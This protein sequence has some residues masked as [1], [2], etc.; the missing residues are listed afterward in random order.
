MG[1]TVKTR[2]GEVRGSTVDGVTVFKGIPYA[3][4]PWGSR[5]M[6][7]PLPV[8]SWSGVRDAT[9]FGAA[10]PALPLAP[11]VA[12]LIPDVGVVPGEDC[13]NLNI[14]TPDM[15]AMGLPVMVWITG[16]FFEFGVGA[17]YD[18]RRFARDGVVCV[19]LNYRA[20]AEGFLDLGDGMADLGLLDQVAALEWVRENIAAFGGD[21]GNVTVFGESAGAMSIAVLLAMPRAE[22]LFRRAIL[23]SGAANAVTPTA[24]AQR[25]ARD[26]AAR[27]GVPA[28]R[29]AIAAV[30]IERMLQAQA[31][32][33]ADL[34]ADP[35]RFGPEVA[36]GRLPWQPSVDGDVVP[37]RPIDRIRAGAGAGIDLIVGTNVDEGRVSLV[38]TGGANGV[39]VEAVAGLAA[40][41]GLPPERALAAYRAAYPDGA[42]GELLAAVQTDGFWRV[43]ALRLADAHAGAPGAT[44][45][46]EFAWPSPA[47]GGLLGACHGLEIAFVFDTLD[48]SFTPMLGPALGTDPPQSLADAM[49]SAWVAFATSGDP[50]W[51]RYD[52]DR[53]ATM[54]FDT[55]SEV[56]DDPRAAERALWADVA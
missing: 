28:T 42:V 1:P 19:T 25:I 37:D 9:A 39:P 38:A 40:T 17:G 23:Q 54:R 11:E 30:P 21:P 2:Y 33:Q 7:P 22:G 26:L 3:A 12:A 41:F 27:L 14:W 49:H 8:E 52:L 48:P 51:P 24:T 29:D 4:P 34:Q 31:Q 6:R 44:Y 32:L 20:G 36:A 13:L 16:G 53:R 43:P 56:I 10:P 46:Y 55:P 45:M 50:G 15:G 35:G 18:G 5:R 47:F